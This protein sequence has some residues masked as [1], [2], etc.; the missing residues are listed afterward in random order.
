MQDSITTLVLDS[1]T[2][3]LNGRP[4]TL[5]G[6]DLESFRR[7][8][9]AKAHQDLPSPTDMRKTRMALR[10]SLADIATALDVDR[11]TVRKWELGQHNMRAD[12]AVKY[13]ILYK[14]MLALI[15]ERN[16]IGRP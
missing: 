1:P 14:E 11:S 5:V 16:E 3:V 4:H 13:M 6:V 15:V 2:P 12:L 9:Q 10:L 7:L 8:V